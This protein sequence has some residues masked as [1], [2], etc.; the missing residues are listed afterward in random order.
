MKRALGTNC[1]GGWLG[2]RA[3]LD[4]VAKSKIS[5]FCRD[6][7]PGRPAIYIGESAC[8]NWEKTQRNSNRHGWSGLG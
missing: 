7:N 6:S 5:I 1:T 4:V 3:G 8:G 2:P